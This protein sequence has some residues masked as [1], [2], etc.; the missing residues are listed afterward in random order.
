LSDRLCGTVSIIAG[1]GARNSAQVHEKN[2]T[3]KPQKF[4]GSFGEKADPL[5]QPTESLNDRSF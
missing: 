3:I 1:T 5:R 4:P 2:A